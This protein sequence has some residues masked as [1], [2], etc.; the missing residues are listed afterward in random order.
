[1]VGSAKR[2]FVKQ[3]VGLAV[4]AAL[5][6]L[7]AAADAQAPHVRGWLGIAMDEGGAAAA[8]AAGAPGAAPP[9]A[10]PGVH[11]GHVVRGSPADKVGIH[12]NDRVL[13]VDGVA[14]AKPADVIQRVGLH[15]LGESVTISL[16]RAGKETPL[17]ATLAAFPAPEEMLRMDTVG[18]FA[19]PFSGLVPLAGFPETLRA[20]RGR[21]I[22]LDFWASW[23]GPCRILSPVLSGWQAR[24]GAQGLTVIGVTTDPPELAATAKEALGMRY[25]VASDAQAETSKAYGVSALP[26][27]FVIDK[28]GVVRDVSVGYDPGHDAAAEALV[29]TLLAE[30]APAD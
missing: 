28:K 19:P 11:I 8:P 25:P 7:G 26:T 13:K 2:Q 18:A 21:V 29:K 5:L 12:E 14:V 20:V 22:V 1:V 15:T 6:A 3:G 23:C 30:P 16:A 24:Y 17:K 9:A 4:G 27:L 10:V